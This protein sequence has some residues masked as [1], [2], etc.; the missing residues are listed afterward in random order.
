M[1][2]V[3]FQAQNHPQQANARGARDA[4]DD[5]A[6]T[7]EVF[8][9]LHERFAFTLDVAASEDNAKCARF[10][11]MHNDGLAKSWEGERVWCNPPYSDIRPWVEKA[12]A[13]DAEIVAMLL[14]ANRT[15]QGWWQ[16]LVEPYRDRPGSPLTCE[17][18]R[19]RLRFIAPDADTVG[20]NE[21][22]P[23]GC[24]L[25]IWNRQRPHL[26]GI[27]ASLDIKPNREPRDGREL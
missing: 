3:G 17:F 8:D 20:P 21:R 15:E 12:W 10:F 26:Q 1:S 13:E 7:P 19:G 27:Q 24:V 11:S 9:P 18:I 25:L 22:P 5:R 16:D 14:P 6:T 23:F 2:L 4:V